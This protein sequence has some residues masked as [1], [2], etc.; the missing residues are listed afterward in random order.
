MGN[1][2]SSRDS[3]TVGTPPNSHNSD[4]YVRLKLLAELYVVSLF[5][6]FW[7]KSPKIAEKNELVFFVVIWSA[8]RP[9][10]FHWKALYLKLLGNMYLTDYSSQILFHC[11]RLCSRESPF[12]GLFSYHDAMYL[13]PDIFWTVN[14]DSLFDGNMANNF[15]RL[16]HGWIHSSK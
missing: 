13:R 5:D 12:L 7:V 6:F 16:F 3:E 8:C 1:Q 2:T 14:S 15:G 9:V 11:D 4:Q 10:F